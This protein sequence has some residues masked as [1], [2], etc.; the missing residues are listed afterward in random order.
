[1]NAYERGMGLL[2][3]RGRIPV[4]PLPNVTLFPH[5]SLPLHIFE[6]RYRRMTRDVLAADRLMAVAQ[7]KAGWETRYYDNPEVH[8]VACAGIVEDEAALPDGRFNIRLRGLARVE[9]LGFVR[10]S[11]YRVAAVRVLEERNAGEGPLA[12]EEKHRLL[13]SCSGLL[14]EMAGQAMPPLV[15]DGEL[16]FAVAV[17]TLCQN[18]AMDPETKQGFLAMNDVVERCRALTEMLTR[19][20]EEIALQQAARGQTPQGGVH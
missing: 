11:P 14:Q 15:L 18:L 19:R 7:L 20:W 16:P 13:V 5:V 2:V 6:P 10:D 4:F 1:M 3:A 9:I 12:D 17:N 8:P